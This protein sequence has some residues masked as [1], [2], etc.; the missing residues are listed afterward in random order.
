MRLAV[1]FLVG[2]TVLL[3]SCAPGICDDFD[4]MEHAEHFVISEARAA[5]LVAAAADGGAGRPTC[6][7]DCLAMPHSANTVGACSV[8]DPTDGGVTLSCAFSN[9]CR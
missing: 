7:E 8:G 5:V 4:A 2:A 1:P 6:Q 9:V 3:A